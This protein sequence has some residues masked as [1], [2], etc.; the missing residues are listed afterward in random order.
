[1]RALS[2]VLPI[3]LMSPQAHALRPPPPIVSDQLKEGATIIE[4]TV[5]PVRNALVELDG[6]KLPVRYFPLGDITYTSADVPELIELLLRVDWTAT[7]PCPT[8]K[9]Q[10]LIPRIRLC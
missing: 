2:L 4:A 6:E 10:G 5:Q 7:L 1:M 9:F 8:R 3:L